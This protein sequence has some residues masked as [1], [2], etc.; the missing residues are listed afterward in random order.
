MPMEFT[1]NKYDPNTKKI[2]KKKITPRTKIINLGGS[3]LTKT[4]DISKS[5]VDLVK[6]TINRQK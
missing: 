2:V 1:Q 6:K 5:T 4:Q 3:L